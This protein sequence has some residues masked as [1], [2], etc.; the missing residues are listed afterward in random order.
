MNKPKIY[1][2][3]T[4]LFICTS[5]WLYADGDISSGIVLQVLDVD[6]YTYLEIEEGDVT[7]WLATSSVGVSKGDRVEYKGGMEMRSFYSRQL[8]RTFNSI[9][10]LG[11]IQVIK[12][13]NGPH[14]VQ[15][16]PATGINNSQAAIAPLLGEINPLE[17]GLIIA[18]ILTDKQGLEGQTVRLWNFAT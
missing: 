7:T 14:D 13:G 15:S 5:S 4:I 11:G 1:S 16:D 18:N 9:L 2:W 17:G 12:S 3:V 8:D 10:F 6:N